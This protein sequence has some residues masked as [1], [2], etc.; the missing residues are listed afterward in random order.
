MPE[1]PSQ[2]QTC[3]YD[4][5]LNLTSQM[6]NCQFNFTIN[7]WILNNNLLNVLSA[8]LLA[9]SQSHFSII[10]REV[11]VKHNSIV[12]LFCLKSFNGFLLL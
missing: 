2:L 9:R 1:L 12:S 4:Y 6:S 10:S 3:V 5:L 11:F 7:S 8:F